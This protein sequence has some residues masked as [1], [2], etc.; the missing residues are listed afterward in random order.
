[1]RRFFYSLI[2]L[3]GFLPVVSQAE[4]VVKLHKDVEALVVNGEE[5]P[6]SVTTKTKFTLPDGV[7]QLVVRVSKLVQS[8]STD[9]D[10]F[11]SDPLV[12][13]F[14]VSDTELEVLP[15]KRIFSERDIGNFKKSP[16][17]KL[18]D[19][20]GNETQAN[21][22]LLPKGPGLMRD[23]QKEI[24][25]FNKKYGLKFQK[26][27]ELQSGP[28]ELDIPTNNSSVPVPAAVAATV[29]APEEATTPKVNTTKAA[30][31]QKSVQSNPGHSMILMQA[32]FLRLDVEEQQQFLRWA[33]E[34]VG[35]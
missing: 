13:T 2:I 16:S 23:H 35:S 4:V 18:V 28:A 22:T 29:L 30:A 3:M 20:K 8:T 33:V 17:F 6:L 12:L 1:M 5:L 32:D 25:L 9:W 21:Q 14:N 7:N 24:N 34:N 15:T 27:E 26:A 10:K 31:A 19:S 11:K